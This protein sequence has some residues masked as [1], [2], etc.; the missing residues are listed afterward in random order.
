MG[1]QEHRQAKR[2]SA[3]NFINAFF[4][5]HRFTMIERSKNSYST[6]LY[7]FV[8]DIPV[9]CPSCES[10]AI[11]KTKDY[12]LMQREENEIQLVCTACGYN[13]KL[14]KVS[15][16]V[17]TSQKQG[18]ILI[19]GA[20]VDPFFHLPLW[21]RL[22]LM[23]ETLWAYNL[24]HLSLLEQHIGAKLRERNQQTTRI[25]SIG[26]RLPKWMTAARN[27]KELLSAIEKLKN[28][29]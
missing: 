22:D 8:K 29:T 20:P 10:K 23:G 21:Y 25:R 27:R 5:S 26:A 28:K 7:E 2:S 12:H 4:P 19:F 24:E 11:V 18:Q 9:V 14:A 15:H 1:L 17:N 13:Q 16:R 6:M 3:Q